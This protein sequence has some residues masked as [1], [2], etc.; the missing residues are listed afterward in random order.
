M[1][2]VKA[3]GGAGLNWDGIAQDV[4]ELHG[5]IGIVL[6]HGAS[7][8]RNQIAARLGIPVR[9]VVSPS[10]ISSVRTDAE[11]ME[12]FLMAYSG[13]ANKRIVAC[14]Q[15]HGANAVGLS[16]V[17][18]RLWQAR[19]KKDLLVREGS[20]T[21]LLRDNLTGRVEKVNTDLI[22][23]LLDHGYLPVVS[24]PAISYEHEIVNTDND[25]AAAAMA[26]GL[27]VRTMVYLFEAPGFLE[28]AER[29]ESLVAH[30]PRAQIDS[31]LTCAQG[32][33]K[34]KLL[35][36]RQ[37]LDSGIETIFFGDGRVEHPVKDA[38][39]GHGTVLS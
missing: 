10:G 2:L 21:K 37:A 19:A 31:F 4:A 35:G 18:G 29:P 23:L 25:T 5:S 32:R 30:I 14:L 27:G 17:D 9:T 24:A 39:S 26:A 12:I 6:V 13:L 15:R 7:A 1:I 3:G 38:L 34:R 11:A 33:M 8:L 28:D 20:R 22:R 36:A 16:G